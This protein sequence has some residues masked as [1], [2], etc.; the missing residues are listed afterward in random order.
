MSFA[1]NIHEGGDKIGQADSDKD[2]DSTVTEAISRAFVADVVN[3]VQSPQIC[4]G[5][6]LSQDYLSIPDTVSQIIYQTQ[7]SLF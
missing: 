5:Q 1:W 2:D 6:K 7:D 3:I 4:P